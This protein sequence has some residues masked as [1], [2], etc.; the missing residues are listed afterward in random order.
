MSTRTAGVPEK[1]SRELP[2]HRAV[3]SDQNRAPARSAHILR[4]SCRSFS[5]GGRAGAAQHVCKA[6][7]AGFGG[8]QV[9]RCSATRPPRARGAPRVFIGCHTRPARAACSQSQ[10]Q[11][12]Q[13]AA[14]SDVKRWQKACLHDTPASM[15]AATRRRTSVHAVR[16]RS[17]CCT[18][19]A[20]APEQQTWNRRVGLGLTSAHTPQAAAQRTPREMRAAHTAAMPPG[21]PL[22][23][24]A[25][26]IARVQLARHA[27]LRRSTSW[28]T[29]LRRSVRAET[30]AANVP[31]AALERE[32]ASW[33]VAAPAAHLPHCAPVDILLRSHSAL[34]SGAFCGGSAAR[35]A[36]APSG[37][38]QRAAAGA[39]RPWVRY[40]ARRNANPK[41]MTPLCEAFPRAARAAAAQAAAP[42]PSL[43]WSRAKPGEEAAVERAGREE[44]I[45]RTNDVHLPR[46]AQGPTEV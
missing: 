39:W 42:Y 12:L 11:L 32:R 37:R 1:R 18:D 15:R 46:H 19:P 2:R 30:A 21:A 5:A 9:R 45:L 34:T 16:P 25:P 31:R 22:R 17:A 14:Q 43:G 28:R 38:A 33:A 20:A 36:G 13:A 24:H 27:G 35:R 40:G 44:G 7:P 3:I 41:R 8:V 26:Y 6:A 29:Q 23:E 4:T 10:P